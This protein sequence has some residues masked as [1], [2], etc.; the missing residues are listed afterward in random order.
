M[1]LPSLERC[2]ASILLSLLL[3]VYALRKRS[4]SLSGAL[5]AIVVG[6]VLT[7]A[8]GCF[9]LALLAFFLTSSR[10]TKWK[11]SQKKKLEYDH[12]EGTANLIGTVAC[13]DKCS[14]Q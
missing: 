1:L 9:C 2:C 5:V 3:L 10:L 14:I 13:I 12:K 6:I 8:S 11:A 7:C 4:L